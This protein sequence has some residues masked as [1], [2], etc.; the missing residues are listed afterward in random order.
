MAKVAGVGYAVFDAAGEVGRF[1]LMVANG[2]EERIGGARHVAVE[3]I[4]A[5]GVR[6]VV[7]VLGNGRVVLGLL[8]TLRAGVAGVH[9]RFELIVGIALMHGMAGEARHLALGI[10]FGHCHAGDYR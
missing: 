8:V 4:A 9:A 1:D 10:T 3:A 2:R 5:C 7:R 6:G